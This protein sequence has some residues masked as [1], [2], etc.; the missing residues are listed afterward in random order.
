[1]ADIR[2]N[3]LR[4]TETARLV[5]WIEANRER[6]AQQELSR[7]EVARQAAEALRFTITEGNIKGVCLDMGFAWAHPKS[8]NGGL[9]NLIAEV[10]RRLDGV[11]ADLG[12]LEEGG[13]A[14][15]AD[16]ARLEA[17]KVAQQTQL[18]GHAARVTPLENATARGRA[19][20]DRLEADS[21]LLR[22]AVSYLYDSLRIKP[23][24]GTGIVTRADEP[25]LAAPPQAKALPHGHNGKR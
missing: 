21:A 1:M 19:D 4:A 5:Q 20:I 23:P 14:T 7:P 9:L 18:D 10:R 8:A 12:R 15:K 25:R 2:R 11:S 22:A 3:N 13:A 16:V 6:I 24:P 17:D